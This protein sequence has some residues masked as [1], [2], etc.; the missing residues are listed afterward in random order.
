[1]AAGGLR[2][3]LSF[4]TALEVTSTSNNL[5]DFLGRSKLV[6]IISELIACKATGIS[7]FKSGIDLEKEKNI[8][9][10]RE[11]DLDEVKHEFRNAR[12][13]WFSVEATRLADM[14]CNL[15]CRH[16]TLC[17]PVEVMNAADCK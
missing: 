16:G 12:V 10:T 2:R 11:E 5:A 8:F 4:A 17:L 15:I 9:R 3:G 13:D 14:G 6:S 7:K 1:V